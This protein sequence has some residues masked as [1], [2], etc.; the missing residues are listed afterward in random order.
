MILNGSPVDP[1]NREYLAALASV[2]CVVAL[3]EPVRNAS[4]NGFDGKIDAPSLRTIHHL[5]AG[6]LWQGKMSLDAFQ[7]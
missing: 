6:L 7:S 3:K 4:A 2:E 5:G 1:E